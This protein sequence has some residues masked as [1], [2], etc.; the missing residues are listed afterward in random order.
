MPD[1]SHMTRSDAERFTAAL[2]GVV[3]RDFWGAGAKNASGATVIT[4][5]SQDGDAQ[6]ARL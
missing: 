2:Y 1:W 3:M 4:P 6:N 5:A